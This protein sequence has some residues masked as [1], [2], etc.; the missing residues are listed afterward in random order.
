MP[1]AS[2]TPKASSTSQRTDPRPRHIDGSAVWARLK[3]ARPDRH[4]VYVNKGDTEALAYY[5]SIGYEVETLQPG[6]VHPAG[7]KTGQVGQPIEVRGLVLHSIDI[8]RH[9]QI[10]LEGPDGD[11]GQL[12]ADRVEDIIVDRNGIDPLRGMHTR[13]LIVRNET[14]RPTEVLQ[15]D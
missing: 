9:R 5:D 15:N 11:S 13:G 7:G 2:R 4:Y 14:Q 8:E 1:A 3:N 10:V 6:G 12:G